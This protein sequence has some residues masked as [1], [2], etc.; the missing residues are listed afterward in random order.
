M[1]LIVFR[2]KAAGEIFMFAE[3]AQRIFEIVGKAA[4]PRGVLTAAEVPAALERLLAA[5]EAEKASLKAASQAQRGDSG[6]AADDDAAV[7]RGVTLGQRA[8][9]L[10]EMLRAAQRKAVDV[11]WGV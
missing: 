5:V 8:F 7:A 11:T 3:T 10:L 9:P 2:C 6:N 4:A 1:A